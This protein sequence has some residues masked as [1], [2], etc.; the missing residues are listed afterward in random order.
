MLQVAVGHSNDPDSRYAVTEVITQC[1][2]TL[3]GNLPQ[4]GI[5]FAAIDFDHVFILAEIQHAFP[6]ISLIGGTS[7]AEISSVLEYQQDSLTLMVFCSDEIEIT[8]GMGRGVSKNAS[9]A[10]ADAVNQAKLNITKE[11]QFCL[12]T[13]ESLTA[14][15]VEILNGLQQALGINFP[16]FGGTTADSYYFQKTY[17]FFNHE[18]ASDSIPILLFSGDLIF[19]HGVASGW[20]PVSKAAKVTKSKA[21]I[22]YEIDGQTAVSFYR[23]YLGGMLPS[24]D[25]PL[26]VFEAEKD[27]FYI[28]EMNGNCDL[29]MGSI[30]FFADVPKGSLVQ[31]AEA[32]REEILVAVENA[33]SQAIKTYSGEEPTAALF[34]SCSAR[35]SFLG[36][37]VQA[38]YLKL[39]SHIPNIPCCGFYTYGEISP[40]PNNNKSL[41]HNETVV[42]LLIG[43][44]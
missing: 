25:Y 11:P 22:V 4:A 5:L 19:A 40:L 16:I 38:E 15:G 33:I 6:G 32:N 39:K 20:K 7:E 43:T 42:V 29:E 35:K 9:L 34:L 23:N 44:R 28:R 31:I 41:F 30:S 12:T 1:Q 26:A 37:Q 10:A 17:Q 2:T 36:T 27:D 13:P 3:A 21:N 8:A 14:S 24:S 18:V